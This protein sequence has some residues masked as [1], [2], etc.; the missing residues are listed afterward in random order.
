MTAQ[1][2]SR[3]KAL[4]IPN[5]DAR[6]GSLVNVTKPQT[7]CFTTA[8]ELR[9]PLYSRLSEYIYFMVQQPLLGQGFF[10]I[11]ASQSH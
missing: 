11:E 10:I 2:R 1:G 9:Y 5:L 6:L 8:K 4:L 7:R 3:G